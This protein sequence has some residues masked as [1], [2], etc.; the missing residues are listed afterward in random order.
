M[1][2]TRMETTLDK[3]LDT[4]L[5]L[6]V[7]GERPKADLVSGPLDLAKVR[8]R[9]EN[10]KGQAYW[11]SLEELAE[12][13]E[14]EE[15]VAKEFPRQAAPLEG[16][17]DRRSFMKLLGA[18]LALAG[19]TSCVR[20]YQQEKIV[21]YVKAPEELIPGEPIYFASALTQ[22]GYAT[23][24]L[25]ESQQGRPTK[26]E[27]N[28]DHPASLGSSS[29]QMQ[30][31]TLGLYDPD[32]S[33]FV[34]SGDQVA[35]YGDFTQ[36]L[37][38]TLQGLGDGT[39]FY[40]LSE[41][42]TSPTLARQLAAL[43]TKY[44][45]AQWHQFD[46]L[47]G[48]SV[49][50]SQLAFGE[51]AAVRYDFSKADT[52]L[53]LDADFLGSGPGQLAYS[54][55]FA[56]RRR[57]RSAED[58]MNRVYVIESSPTVTGSMSD[59]RLA[60]RPSQITAA[61]Y[62]LAVNLGVEGVERAELPEGLEQAWLDAVTEDLT[63]TEGRSIVIAGDEQPASVHVL[64]A[65]MNQTLGNVGQTVL[66][67]DPVAVQPLE[68]LA[69]LQGLTEAMN[70]GQVQ[71]LLMLGGN[72]VY[73]APSDLAFADALAKVPVSVHHSLYVDE[74]SSASTWH[75]PATHDLETWSDARAFDGTASIMQP[76]IEPFY[77]GFSVHEVLAAALGDTE[78][79]PYDVVRA[80][81]QEQ[82]QGDFETFW[83]QT[84]YAGTVGGTTL[85]AKALELQ[86]NAIEQAGTSAQASASA[87][88]A[89]LAA[90]NARRAAVVANAVVGAATSSGGATATPAV[91]S[92][93][94][95]LE[96]AF[97]L[98]P[99]IL[100]GRY[101]N[102]GWLQ[103]LPN[104]FTK[105]TWDNAAL[106]APALAERQGLGNG[107][108]VA[109]TLGER[110]L[111]LPVWL[112]PGQADN[113]ILLHLGYGRKAAG[114]VGNDLG[115]NVNTLRTSAALWHATGAQLR[116]TGKTYT[117]VSTQMHHALDTDGVEERHIIRHGTL[118]ELQAE[119]EHPH[120]VH[121]VEHPESN[122]YAPY[123]YEGHAWGMVVD[124]NVCTGCNACVTACQSENNIPIVG[125]SQVQIGRELQWIRVDAYYGGSVDEPSFYHM[126]MM[127]QHCEQAP[128][129]P[130]CPVGATTHDSEGLN[131]MV[132]NRCV[133]T[134]YCSNNCPYKVR[135][136][137]F[138]QYAELDDT[139]LAM[140][141]NPN[142]TVR[143][144]GVMEK[145]TYCVQ[146]I[147]ATTIR[148]GNEDREVRDGEIVTACQSACPTQA[149]VFGDINNP[150]SQV[151]AARN[152]VLNYGVLTELNTA[153]RTTYLTKLTNPHPALAEPNAEAEVATGAH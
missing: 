10:Q 57:V 153:P 88:A 32:R 66:Y 23:G 113:L 42:V 121:P 92:E 41:T 140:L 125:K 65:A 81:Y 22:G 133:G 89:T 117:L 14:F 137:N 108:M 1:T 52:V 144:R 39:G 58:T 31:A 21:P 2:R 28:P 49:A 100:D 103:E 90:D 47:S 71:L 17:V 131:V 86:G 101:S 18:S 127:C 51:Q 16:S 50:G 130:V 25:V 55:A 26:I 115:F 96:V 142:V 111:E 4:L 143:S 68:Q 78:S 59:H 54:R 76:L 124:M 141:A 109:V 135:R 30:A 69:S 102:S 62:A 83:R 110:S 91:S 114:H 67:T 87:A 93:A 94:S 48:N 136:F 132:Y 149:I 64:A 128:C 13:P 53:S 82:F 24:V 20:P 148:A 3:T 145:C 35:S 147:K 146:R 129:E 134:R 7:I 9:L 122:L 152:S 27:G 6:P 118:A 123:T 70:G 12:T 72:P 44:P 84:V 75:V 34:L 15:F 126:P 107:D 43:L 19:L 77:N 99:S 79:T 8:S 151:T 60:L 150:D 95:G 11:R 105:L 63:G 139:S 29:A 61:A 5:E 36:V 45:K 104:P 119:P 40:I 56:E 120:F 116:P 112:N 73:S 106:I 38:T 74:T 37:S 98:D 85:E 33:Q 46:G 138:L 80:T 97:R